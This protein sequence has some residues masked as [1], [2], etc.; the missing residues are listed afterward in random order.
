MK[1]FKTLE[2]I[3]FFILFNHHKMKKKKKEKKEC[4]YKANI[5]NRISTFYAIYIYTLYLG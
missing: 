3:K 5:I 4:L 2:N 1:H